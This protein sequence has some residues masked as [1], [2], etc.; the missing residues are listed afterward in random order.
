VLVTGLHQILDDAAQEIASV[1]PQ[2][3]FGD[4]FANLPASAA[5]IAK[6]HLTTLGA[7]IDNNRPADL[8]LLANAMVTG[9]IPNAASLVSIIVSWV[10]NTIGASAIP[11]GSSAVRLMS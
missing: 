6:E 3:A 11:E 4:R 10:V 2:I 1:A 5:A 9:G 8:L 7:T